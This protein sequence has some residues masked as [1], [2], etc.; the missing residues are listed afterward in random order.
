LSGLAVD[1][2]PMLG[3]CRPGDHHLGDQEPRAEEWTM[4]MAGDLG[5]PRE[6]AVAAVGL[7]KVYGQGDT[8]VVALDEVEVSFARG[9]F[10]SIMGPSGSGKSTLLHC[11]AGLD[12]PTSGQVVIGGAELTSMA[13][14]VVTRL[15]RDRIGF[16]F[17]AYNLIPTL[18]ALENIT[19]PLALAGRQPDRELL[20]AVIVAL[21]LK[22]RLQHKPAQLSG[23]EQQ[24]VACARAL[25]ARPAVV[26]ADEPTG[27]LDSR[28]GAEVLGVLRR[29]VDE[30]GQTIAMVTHDPI[31]AAHADRVLLLVDGRIVDELAQPTAEGV[32]E[33][34]TR[35]DSERG[36]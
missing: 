30:L 19:L 5:A 15:R 21:S 9:Q 12:R 33:R 32:L 18:T 34:V 35:L 23:G 20:D 26:F 25:V 3:P 13:D 31:A 6:A 17:Q 24:R 36:L 29:A 11:L 4:T 7:R 1:Q 16:V 27:N 2:W 28:S 22:D 10:T 14:D 8:G